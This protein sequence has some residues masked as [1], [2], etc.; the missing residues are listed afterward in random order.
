MHRK[1]QRHPLQIQLIRVSIKTDLESL[2]SEDNPFFIP[3]IKE[4]EVSVTWALQSKW[5]I[6]F[7]ALSNFR[8]DQF[9]S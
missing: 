7:I 5:D 6:E 8:E 4:T 3:E 1:H 9:V 2:R